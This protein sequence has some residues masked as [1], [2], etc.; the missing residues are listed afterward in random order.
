MKTRLLTYTF[1]FFSLYSQAQQLV[2]SST[3]A[4]QQG[5]ATEEI[6]PSV[7]IKNNGSY[8]MELRWE[9]VKNNLPQGWESVVCDKLCHTAYT[10]SKSFSLAPGE[11]IYD[12]RVSFHPN[13]F[14]GSGHSE[15]KIYELKNPNNHVN[16]SFNASSN[17]SSAGNGPNIYPN[18]ATEH[19]MVQDPNNEVK[20]IEVYNIVGKKI[21]EFTINN[22]SGKYDVSDLQR[23]M[24]MIRM[25]DRNRNIIRTQRVSK[26]NP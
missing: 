23:G 15:I 14:E 26:Y 12:F 2:V 10:E 24:Y 8:T 19:I 17:A 3:N 22:A 13:G 9:R 7:V 1:L 21:S 5:K 20:F 6:N 18:P 25:L 11:S 4:S 16:V